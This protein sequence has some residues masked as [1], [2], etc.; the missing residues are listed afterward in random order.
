MEA[1]S[2]GPCYWSV[3]WYG[4]GNFCLAQRNLFFF[5]DELNQTTEGDMVLHPASLFRSVKKGSS[6]GFFSK[7]MFSIC[8]RIWNGG[9]FTSPGFFYKRKMSFSSEHS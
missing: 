5:S 7:R 4:F 8:E 6:L 9:L 2:T 1:E 3:L